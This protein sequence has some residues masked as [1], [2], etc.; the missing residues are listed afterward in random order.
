MISFTD[1]ELLARAS[2]DERHREAER[3]RM[4]HEVAKRQPSVR[5]ATARR[6]TGIAL[7][8]DQEATY[9]WAAAYTLPGES[10]PS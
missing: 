8:I 4:R 9:R 2:I 3:N 6:L 7:L 5:A 10:A 1:H